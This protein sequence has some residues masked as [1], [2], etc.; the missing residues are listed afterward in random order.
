MSSGGHE[1]RL[2]DDVGKVYKGSP[3]HRFNDSKGADRGGKHIDIGPT[4]MLD[5]ERCILCS[6]CVRFMRDVAGDEQLYI[7]GRG[8]HAYIT[9]FPGDDLNHDYDLCTTDVCPV[10]ALTGKHFRFQQRVWFLKTTNSVVPDDSLGANITIDYNRD[11]VWRLMPRRNPHVNKSWLHNESRLLYQKLDENR[12]LQG[13]RDGKAS[14]GNDALVAAGQILK[15]ANKIA[16]VASGHS[17]SETQAAV[18]ALAESLGNRAQLFF[19]SWMAVGEGDGIARSG[20][21]VFNR[22]GALKQGLVDNLDTLTERAGEFDCLLC[23]EHDLWGI[24]AEKAKALSG[25]KHRIA[26][27]SWD[28][29]TVA[30]STIAVGVRSWAEARGSMINCQGRVQQMGA[31][32]VLPDQDLESPWEAICRLSSHAADAPIPWASF[33][34]AWKAVADAVEGLA[35]VPYRKLGPE[36]L[37]LEVAEP[38]E[39]A[40]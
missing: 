9:T 18:K 17:S 40:E 8:D 6:R 23:V 27:A 26:L 3:D 38:V 19:G 13:R 14:T 22:H 25:I 39:A 7:A 28:D 30:Q 4:V 32:P 36:G 20:D 37:Q 31:C 34:D 21:P 5:Q 35:G 15:T 16:I 2:E 11:K 12:L 33:G 24:D 1:S 29:E 10:G